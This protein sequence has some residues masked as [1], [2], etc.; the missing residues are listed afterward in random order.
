MQ[1]AIVIVVVLL[2]SC[3]KH[4]HLDPLRGLSS[5][6]VMPSMDWRSPQRFDP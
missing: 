4:F 6:I 3:E 1:T 5:L 2:G